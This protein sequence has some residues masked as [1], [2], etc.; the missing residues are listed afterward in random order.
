[1]DKLKGVAK[2]GWHPSGDR[3]IHR[4]TWKSDLKGIATGKKNDPY[5]AARSHQSAPLSTLKDPDSFGPPPKHSAY[6][7][8]QS[9]TALAQPS[10]AVSRP[11][12]PSG[13]GA[14][15]PS[16][17]VK[18][19]KEEATSKPAVPYRMN[20]TGLRTDNLP[21]PPTRTLGGPE[22]SPVPSPS[23][24]SPPVLPGR[25]AAVQNHV[26]KPAQMKPPPALPPRQNEFP[27]EHTPAPPPS[28]QQAAQVINGNSHLIN[29]GASH[30]L[31]QAGVSVPDFG[32]GTP[33]QKTRAQA[34]IGTTP[35]SELQQRFAQMNTS[36]SSS[37]GSSAATVSNLKAA[38]GKKA[39]PPP[40]PVKK[41]AVTAVQGAVAS[42]DTGHTVP[43][44]IPLQ[45][46]PRP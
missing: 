46:K 41:A 15:I 1:M 2:G 13:W 12:E 36:S 31:N 27:D 42:A 37:Q 40:P 30:K 45:S 29:Q 28:Y 35:V 26:Q 4:D 3:A 25:Q 21:K 14:R 11:P 23:R 33:A 7:G 20:T 32:I 38:A 18:K 24:P 39:A 19:E 22:D 44:P 43:P 34:D 9:P 6:Y 16:P 5:E 10:S 8:S 17:Q